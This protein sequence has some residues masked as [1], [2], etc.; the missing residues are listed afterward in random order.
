MPEN[1]PKSKPAEP[2]SYYEFFNRA[3]KLI[4]GTGTQFD[5]G[6]DLDQDRM[7]QLY[8]EL[9]ERGPVKVK[10]AAKPAAGKHLRP[11]PAPGAECPKGDC[12]NARLKVDKHGHSYY[13]QRPKHT[14]CCFEPW[15]HNER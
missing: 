13:C 12:R 1:T 8:D 4:V 3:R 2:M 11:D 14:E 10:E 5:P 7:R 15:G 9:A 6:F